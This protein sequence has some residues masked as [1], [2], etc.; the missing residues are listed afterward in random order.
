MVM[1]A[2]IGQYRK[3]SEGILPGKVSGNRTTNAIANSMGVGCADMYAA[4]NTSYMDTGL[5]GFYAQCDEVAVNHCVSELMFGITGL[6][7]KVTDDEVCR[8][9]LQLMTSLFGS[10]DSTT[11]VAEDIGR[12]VL[13]YGRRISLPEFITR[14]NAIDAEEVKRVAWQRLH[15]TEIAVAAMGPL[16]GLNQLYN[17]RR[18]TVY[19]RY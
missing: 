9:K 5:F 16:H 18:K 10:L 14:L 12:Q 17:L 3:D 19:Y 15:D 13:V 8:A 7:Y 4:F 2:V 11:A 6:A 1:Q